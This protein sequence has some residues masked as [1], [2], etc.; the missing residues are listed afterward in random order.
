[1][2][3]ELNEVVKEDKLKGCNREMLIQKCQTLINVMHLTKD[4]TE[5]DSLI[6]SKVINKHLKHFFNI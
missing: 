3:Q 1:M 5:F 4:Y 6:L 2:I